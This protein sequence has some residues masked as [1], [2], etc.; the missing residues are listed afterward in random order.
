MNALRISALVLLSGCGPLS[1]LDAAPPMNAWVHLREFDGVG[2]RT[3]AVSL[4]PEDSAKCPTVDEAV[5]LD[6]VEVP[7][8]D[9]GGLGS[10]PNTRLFS[11][12]CRSPSWWREQQTS[13][14]REGAPVT[15]KFEPSNAVLETAPIVLARPA[16]TT[17]KQVRRG[18][19]IRLALPA[20]GTHIV[21][22][23]AFKGEAALTPEQA[24][25]QRTELSA[26]GREVQVFVSDVTGPYEVSVG[27]TSSLEVVRCEGFVKCEVQLEYDSVT[28]FEVLP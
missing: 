3:V 26:D 8:S 10:G 17:P 6:G 27:T 2:P 7:L 23:V 4:S 16:L 28:S 20:G 18:E 24:F 14:I 19:P 12:G 11:D 22:G 15:V 9:S 5:T 21:Y 13:L 25:S 1:R